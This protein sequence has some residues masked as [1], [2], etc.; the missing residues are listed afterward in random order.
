MLTAIIND[1]HFWQSN[2]RGENSCH[3]NTKQLQQ[4]NIQ[5]I[6]WTVAITSSNEFKMSYKRFPKSARKVL[7]FVPIDSVKASIDRYPAEKELWI[8]TVD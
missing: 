1:K 7:L 2:T 5:G 3:G 6:A 8:A 4:P